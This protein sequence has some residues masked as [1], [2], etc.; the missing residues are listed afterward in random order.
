[1]DRETPQYTFDDK[2]GFYRAPR[3]I[4][5]GVLREGN[6]IGLNTDPCLSITQICHGMPISNFLN[7]LPGFN[8]FATLHDGWGE[9]MNQGGNW[10]LAT[11][12]GSMPAAFLV[13]YGAIFDQYSYINA[14][15]R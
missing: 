8:A 7:T 2:N 10:N 14:K 5:D 6:N 4:I 15:R 12:L 3:E 1:V 13:S 9:S 11:N